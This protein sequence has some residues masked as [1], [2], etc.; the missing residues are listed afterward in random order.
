ME[1]AVYG[2]PR[3]RPPSGTY[4]GADF[5]THAVARRRENTDKSKEPAKKELNKYCFLV[6]FGSV[7][8]VCV[9]SC[10]GRS[11]GIPL[12]LPLFFILCVA[13]SLRGP[14]PCGSRFL[15]FVILGESA[16][17]RSRTILWQ[18]STSAFPRYNKQPKNGMKKAR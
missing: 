3:R 5:G 18:P 10:F 11:L 14:R 2:I 16:G 17:L 12:Y 13:G 9:L 6:L 8:E 7:F 4:T 1:K 15:L